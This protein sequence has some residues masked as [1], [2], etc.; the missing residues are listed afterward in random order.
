[1]MGTALPARF[2]ALAAEAAAHANR[3]ELEAAASAW[4][5]AL[6]ILPAHAQAWHNLGIVEARRGRIDEA[7]RAF[8]E[9]A[10]LRPGWAEPCYASGHA[11]LLHGDAHA[12]AVWFERALA[13]DPDHLAARVDLAHA[14]IRQ[15]RYSLAV[16][17]LAHARSLAP[18]EEAI[19][20]LL[21]GTL[22][23]LGREEEALQDLLAFE[24]SGGASGRVKVAA[25][26]SARRLGDA[27]Y[28]ARALAEALAFPYAPGDAALVSEVL[29]LVQY[30]DID[31]PALLALYDAYDRLARG[32]I[33][34]RGEPP[35]AVAAPP[36]GRTSVGYLSADLRGH[37]MGDLLAPVVEAH[38][39][40]AH[41][42]TLFSLA[43]PGHDDAVTARFRAAADDFVD[44]ATLD[45][46]AAARA[47]AERGIDVL[48]DLM[49]HSAFAHPGILARK[50][51]RRIVTHL[52]YHGGVGL[53]SV[54]AKI[55]DPLADLPDGAGA[56]RERL[57]PLDVCVLP[58]RAYRAPAARYPRATLGIA[59]D[60][61]VIAAFVPAQK[62]A[63]RCLALWREVLARVPR[64]RL[65]FSPP[66]DDDRRAL[67]RRLEGFGIG[68]DRVAFVPYEAAHRHDRYALADFALDT[69]P[70]TGG[71]TTAAALAAGVPVVTRSG[72]RHAE[73]MSASIL[74]HAGLTDLIAP[75]DEAFVA[76]ACRIATEDAWR[77]DL[78]RRVRAALAVPSLTDPA[79]YARALERAYARVLSE[80]SRSPH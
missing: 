3:G 29:A 35:L 50:P 33:A 26:A 12:A 28:E 40:N 49:G 43:P 77:D 44:L 22:L 56:L 9:A 8:D 80:P 34:A 79:R 41:R 36:D 76:L 71:D 4:R 5:G 46:A 15:R 54:D 25:L 18:A 39:R 13:V 63:P 69:V 62:L 66:R 57:L 21:R 42:I 51:A 78:C 24:R 37:V 64:A 75:T 23:A 6:A 47:I 74:A 72:R 52:G 55:S 19:W 58:L 68:A 59:A 2:A 20:W 1:M 45:D 70:Y 31:P 10:R 16:P 73:R 67:S 32:E 61:I 65:L 14:L 48:V 30:H 11:T 17:H 7:T 27:Q 38:D 60:A 53:A